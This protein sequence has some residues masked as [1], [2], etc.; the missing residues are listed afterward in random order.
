LFFIRSC[1]ILTALFF[2]VS[3]VTM[4][5]EQSALSVGSYGTLVAFV[6]ADG[7]LAIASDLLIHQSEAANWYDLFK[8]YEVIK[9]LCGSQRDLEK[10]PWS[11]PENKLSNFRHTANSYRH[12]RAHPSREA[13]P[14]SP[15][16]IEEAKEMIRT[17]ADKV[18]QEKSK[19]QTQ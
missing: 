17:M 9:T 7:A 3:H 15:M 13:P 11:P 16:P 14:L 19:R 4:A 2:L 8:S 5:V 12:S 1:L 6:P 18:L 10:R